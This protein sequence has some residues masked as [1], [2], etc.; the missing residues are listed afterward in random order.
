MKKPMRVTLQSVTNQE[1]NI[2]VASPLSFHIDSQD[3]LL[4]M[5]ECLQKRGD[6]TTESAA[7]FALG[8][9]LLS[10]AMAENKNKAIFSDFQPFFR[11]F[12]D[13]LKQSSQQEMLTRYG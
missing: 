8:L 13:L 12:M 3:E 7:S 1:T 10:D 2:Y 6:F 5:A 4:M 11:H 9:K